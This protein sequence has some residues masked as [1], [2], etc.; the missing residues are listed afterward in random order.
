MTFGFEVFLVDLRDRMLRQLTNT[1][2]NANGADWSPDG[3]WMVY[4]RPFHQSPEDSA[5]LYIIDVTSGEDRA[6]FHNGKPVFGG[7]P[8]WSPSG[9]AIAFSAGNRSGDVDLFTI[10]AD[11]TVL[12]QLTNA[13]ADYAMATDPHWMYGGTH[14]LYSWSWRYRDD[15]GSLETRIMRTDGSES[16]TWPLLLRRF[17]TI[18]P[19]SRF[20]ITPGA[21]EDS[22]WVL[23]IREIDDVVGISLRQLTSYTPPQHVGARHVDRTGWGKVLKNSWGKVMRADTLRKIFR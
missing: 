5:S 17:D 7:A 8:R 22:T 4:H 9:N 19:D 21:Q 10:F 3:R 14:L 1:S 23:F 18:S 13:A 6:L 2:H 15:E 11:G 12:R 16:T 20:I